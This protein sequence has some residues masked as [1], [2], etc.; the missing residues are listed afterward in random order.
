MMDIHIPGREPICLEHLLLDYNGTLAEDGHPIPGISDRIQGISKHLTVHVI[1]ADTFGTVEARLG[2]THCRIV[3]IPEPDQVKAKADYLELL[4]PAHTL[5]CGNGANDQAM[6]EAAA[7]GVA[8][9]QAE[10]M[11]ASLLTA[12][13]ILIKDIHHL[14]DLLEKPG[15]MKATLRR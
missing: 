11:A 13:D 10:G 1:T 3:R 7:I 6:L 12:A 2:H 14:F 5:A 8:I 9:L 15:R 4:G